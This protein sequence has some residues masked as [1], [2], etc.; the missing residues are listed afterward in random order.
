MNNT[1]SAKAGLWQEEQHDGQ[2]RRRED[3]GEAQ[4][5]HDFFFY[6]PRRVTAL[7]NYCPSVATVYSLFREPP[8]ALLGTH[9]FVAAFHVPVPHP[10][11]SYFSDRGLPLGRRKPRASPVKKFVVMSFGFSGYR[12]FRPNNI[13]SPRCCESQH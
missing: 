4:D 9:L 6:R 12:R 11:I 1:K 8:L 3:E 2:D 7:S 13:G 5:E 10:A